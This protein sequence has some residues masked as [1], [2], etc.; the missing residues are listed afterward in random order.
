[1]LCSSPDTNLC[2]QLNCCDQLH[3]EFSFTSAVEMREKLKRGKE[4]DSYTASLREFVWYN[5][6]FG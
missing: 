5:L 2:P 6:Y 1:M 4:S 3:G